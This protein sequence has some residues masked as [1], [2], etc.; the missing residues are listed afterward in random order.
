[1]TFACGSACMVSYY[2]T[3]KFLPSPGWRKI[4]PS[5]SMPPGACGTSKAE[6]TALSHSLIPHTTFL[7]AGP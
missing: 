7:L 3:M 2:C 6:L 4:F 1:M 5:F